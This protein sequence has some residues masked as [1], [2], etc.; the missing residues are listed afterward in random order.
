MNISIELHKETDAETMMNYGV[1]KTPAVVID[2]TLVHSG[3][4]PGDTEINGW[5][6]S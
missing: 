3:S 4:I 2:D 1:M 6:A 5:L